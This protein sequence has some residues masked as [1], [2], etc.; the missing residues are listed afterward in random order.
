MLADAWL[1]INVD[2]SK[3]FNPLETIPTVWEET[4]ELYFTWL[5]SRPEYFSFVCKEVFNVQLLPMQ[6]L[7]LK[8]L[9]DRK[10]PMLVGASG[11]GKSWLLGL[12]AL[13]RIVFMRKR[14]VVIVGAAFRQSKVIFEYM[15]TIWNNAPVLRSMCPSS[16]GSKHEQD[17]WRFYIGD[18]VA[19]ALPL[20]DGQKIRGQRANDIINDEFACLGFNTL[21][22]TDIGLIKIKD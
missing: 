1:N 4:P 7:I 19:S 21:I 20:G 5:M 8:E 11:L 6:A 13:L 15:E 12:Y 16:S 9:W 18:S 22:Q 10:F 2:E 3:L 14:K 17:M